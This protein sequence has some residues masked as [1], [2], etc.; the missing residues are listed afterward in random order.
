MEHAERV[1]KDALESIV[2]TFVFILCPK[3]AISSFLSLLLLLF[4]LH[5]F[6]MYRSYLF[7]YFDFLIEQVCPLQ[8]EEGFCNVGIDQDGKCTKC[9]PGFYGPDCLPCKT[10]CLTCENGLTCTECLSN[11]VFSNT[12][13]QSCDISCGTCSHGITGS[14]FMLIH[15]NQQLKMPKFILFPPAVLNFDGMNFPTFIFS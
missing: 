7:L 4:L 8:C 1:K 6:I 11:R 9:L 3:S 10:E 12:C 2:R 13:D 14:Y 5:S 15:K